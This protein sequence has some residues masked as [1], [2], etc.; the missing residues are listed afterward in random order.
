MGIR[1]VD[2]RVVAERLRE[3]NAMY[4][5]FD[6]DDNILNKST[7]VDLYTELFT[8]FLYPPTRVAEVDSNDP[9]S[10]KVQIE[11]L[12][13][14]LSTMWIWVDF[15][16]VEWRIRLGQILWEESKTNNDGHKVD[17][18]AFTKESEKK[19]LMFQILLASELLVRLDAVVKVAEYGKF[20]SIELGH[21]NALRTKSADWNII[22]ARR[23]LENVQVVV[24][25][26][27]ATSNGSEESSGPHDTDA[28]KKSRGWFASIAS[29]VAAGTGDSSNSEHPHQH[30]N[31]PLFLPRHQARQVSGLLYFAK[32]LY[33]PGFP[34]LSA[35]LDPST[36]A[37]PGAAPAGT[38]DATPMSVLSRGD[39]LTMTDGKRRSH[40]RRLQTK[41]PT[42]NRINKL[43]QPFGWLSR[44][45]MTGL[46]LPGEVLSHYLIS[47]LIENDKT[48]VASLG[49]EAN[50][51]GGFM[52]QGRS[53]W[54]T[55]CII[56][57]V[58]ASG[59]RA[60][61]SMGW[62][63]S[64]ITPLKVPDGWVEISTRIQDR[65]RKPRLFEIGKVE[66]ESGVVGDNYMNTIFPGDFTLPTD[67]IIAED[68]ATRAKLDAFTLTPVS[69][70]ALE[71]PDE[72]SGLKS[73]TASLA[74]TLTDL[75]I[76][77]ASSANSSSKQHEHIAT[78]D[79]C[80]D[81]Y[82]LTAHPC[83]PPAGMEILQTPTSPHFPGSASSS[84]PPSSPAAPSGQAPAQLASQPCNHHDK[85][86]HLPAHPLY[87]SYKYHHRSLLSLLEPAT[88]G[89]TDNPHGNND[90]T[91]IDAFVSP[92]PEHHHREP[93][94]ENMGSDEEMLARAWCSER[95]LNALV[96]RRGRCCIACSVR[97]AKAVGW[98]VV[99]R[100]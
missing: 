9:Y 95:G 25:D 63:S 69:A 55:A 59:R 85:H 88:K 56:G 48:A 16:T 70:S 44:S 82:F 89:N 7:S 24:P 43:I 21:F 33:W 71:S 46:I 20:T 81:V 41:N 39:H 94:E 61:E 23:F 2:S 15:S 79:L 68:T 100:I 13:K 87:K 42:Q 3:L 32:A 27:Q 93:E 10:M 77:P 97:E 64:P 86:H 96:S 50:L 54:S 60:G 40:S 51:Y 5:E 45:Y 49:D 84:P 52:H 76:Q 53:F 65:P 72:Q 19:W 22:V 83:V 36:A 34:T 47:T 12:M 75:S 58:L 26:A 35:S 38:D 4:N 30:Y 73:Y 37:S 31:Q 57:R 62:V 17:D 14:V 67:I 1:D 80:H 29:P 8:R 91:V 28:S 99:I 18:E 11:S 66:R 98:S 92:H 90:I 6:K 78:L 74:F